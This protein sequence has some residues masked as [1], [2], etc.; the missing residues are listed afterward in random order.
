MCL[1][2]VLIK[3]IKFG[4]NVGLEILLDKS[5][6]FIMNKIYRQTSNMR[7]ALVG[8]RIVDHFILDLTSGFNIL[9]KGNCKTRREIFKFSN[10]VRLVLET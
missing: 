6:G 1:L 7:H 3:A 8:T 9:H 2:C 10:S 5:P 4:K